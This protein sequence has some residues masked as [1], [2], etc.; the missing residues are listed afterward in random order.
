MQL[1]K[2]NVRELRDYAQ[3]FGI[4]IPPRLDSKK[5]EIISFL[6]EELSPAIPLGGAPKQSD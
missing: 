6:R 4:I 3:D 5:D 1:S 2:L